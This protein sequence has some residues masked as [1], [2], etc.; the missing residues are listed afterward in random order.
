MRTLNVVL[1]SWAPASHF[2]GRILCILCPPPVGFYPTSTAYDHAHC[3]TPG[4]LLLSLGPSMILDN[5]WRSSHGAQHLDKQAAAAGIHAR[6]YPVACRILTFPSLTGKI[7][8]GL[9]CDAPAGADLCDSSHCNPENGL[10]RVAWLRRGGCSLVPKPVRP[11]I[12][13]G[14]PECTAGRSRLGASA[15]HLWS[16][17][18]QYATHLRPPPVQQPPTR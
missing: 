9:P 15:R 10:Q 14:H 8:H 17:L 2:L 1:S 12:G 11:S 18:C 13:L 16:F 3:C 6:A 5:Q 7:S 4:E